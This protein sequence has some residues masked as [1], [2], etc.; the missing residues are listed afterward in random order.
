ME[1][2]KAFMKTRKGLLL[3]GI[4]LFGTI[5]FAFKVSNG[6]PELQPTQRQ[7]LLATVGA[8]LEAQHYSPKVID[9]NFS[10]KLFTAYLKALDPEKTLFLQSDI[11]GFK[12][13]ETSL[14]DEIK[15]API[16]F[17]PAVSAVYTKRLQE[18][19]LLYKEVLKTPFNFN[20][21]DSVLIENDKQDFAITAAARKDRWRKQLTYAALERYADY[22]D[23]REK[24]K[25]KKDYVA[26]PDS[27]LERMAREQVLKATNKRF[28]RI[29]KTFNDDQRFTAFINAI[30]GLMDPHTDYFPPIEKRSFDEGMSGRFYGIGAQLGEDENGIKIASVQ[31]GGAA[32]KSREIDANDVILKVAQGSAEPVD[33]VGYA[34]EDAV[35]IIRGNKGTEVRLT[36][37]KATGTVKVISLIREEIVLDETFARSAIVTEGTDK[38][39]YIYLPEFY[40]DYE[41][42]DGNRCSEDIAKEIVKFKAENVKGIVIDLR[43]NGGGSLYEVI[44]MVGLFI[45]QGPVVQVRDR[46]GKS[47]ILSDRQSGT[48][49]D[50]P[51]AVMVN[52]FSASA[53]EIFAG[54]IQDYKRGVIIGSTSTYGKGTV[55][56]SIPFGNPVDQFSGRTDMGAVKLTFQMFYRVNGASTQLKGVES[57]IVLPDSYEYLKLRE[58][59]NESALPFHKIATAP[60]FLWSQSAVYE[61]AITSEKERVAK[62][63]NFIT[64]KNNLSW[65]A[66]TS[67]G[68]APLNL[69][70]YQALQTKIKKIVDQ[71]S[72]LLKVSK[73]LSVKPV[74][75]D[76]SKFYNNPDKNKGERYKAWLTAIASDMPISETVKVM[77]KMILAKSSFVFK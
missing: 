8:L 4:V 69:S 32:W 42:E 75:I 62:D 68:Y 53:S 65:I 22:L 18:T 23:Q 28:D 73:P 56:R 41:R 74:E 7:K 6:S 64:L 38:I 1:K 39:G 29:Q 26:K 13:F 52:E 35:K 49:Y 36:I 59:D 58:K 24:N 67:E 40:A 50:G 31:P 51:L 33:V 14:D 60:Y 55:Q 72:A 48:L 19:M 17:V 30:T 9:D 63:A 70:N 27:T 3:G 12:K 20:I 45:N 15:G 44:Q 76:N 5:F 46:D 61:S 10:K 43:N 11:A 21:N 66:S 16:A 37:K 57:D 77:N 47:N 54:A 34:T 71:N 2:F 25:G